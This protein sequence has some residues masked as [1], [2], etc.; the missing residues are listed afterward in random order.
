MKYEGSC[1]KI[2]GKEED[3]IW[4]VTA[5]LGEVGDGNGREGESKCRE[6]GRVERATLM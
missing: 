1:R 4:E 3:G 5:S 2:G 6:M